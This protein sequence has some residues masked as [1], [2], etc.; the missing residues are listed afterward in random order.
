[1]RVADAFLETL[2]TRRVPRAMASSRADHSRTNDHE[3]NCRAYSNWGGGKQQAEE[4]AEEWEGDGWG[5]DEGKDEDE[6]GDEDEG[7][8]EDWEESWGEDWAEGEGEGEAAGETEEW[9]AASHAENVPIEDEDEAN[10]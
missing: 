3:S 4:V 10:W 1:M 5:E 8:G 7:E 2:D 9:G 6:G